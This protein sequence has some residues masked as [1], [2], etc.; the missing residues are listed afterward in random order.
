M[1]FKEALESNFKRWFGDSKV[2]DSSGKPMV[3]YHGTGSNI[4]KFHEGKPSYF[5]DKKEVASGIARQHDAGN[6]MPVY[7]RIINPYY[8]KPGDSKLGDFFE[9]IRAAGHDGV[10]SPY[11]GDSKEYIT[12]SSDQVRSAFMADPK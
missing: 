9:K 4:E 12:F 8:F 7:L 2:V 5:T 3:V 11:R 1:R 10:I 6:V